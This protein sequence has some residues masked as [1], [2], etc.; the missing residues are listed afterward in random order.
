MTG[1]GTRRRFMEIGLDPVPP[2][3]GYE[4]PVP[5]AHVNRGHGGHARY[6]APL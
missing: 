6:A 2:R 4:N 1:Q 3:A 5:R